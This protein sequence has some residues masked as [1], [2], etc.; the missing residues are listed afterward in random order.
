MNRSLVW[1]HFKVSKQKGNKKVDCQL[2]DAVLTRGSEDPRYQTTSNMRRHL[3]YKHPDKYKDLVRAEEKRK[4]EKE[5]ENKT[6]FLVF[7]ILMYTKP[8]Q[9]SARH[10]AH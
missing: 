3:E 2:C 1:E 9:A 10:L 8:A 7:V 6:F 4:K 5:G